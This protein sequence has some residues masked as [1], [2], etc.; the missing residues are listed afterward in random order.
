MGRPRLRLTLLATATA[1]VISLA[2]G[3]SPALAAPCDVPI[4]N[5][6]ACENTKPGNPA[7]EWDVS[8]AGSASIQGFATDISV[9]QG[10]TVSFKVDTPATAYRIDIYR[11]GYYGGSGARRVATVRPTVLLPQNQPNCVTPAATGLS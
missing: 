3:A 11:M 7:S 8:G 5:P 9:D 4:T 6:V 1:A 2:G 10:G